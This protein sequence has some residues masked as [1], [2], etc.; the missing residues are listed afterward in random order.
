[1]REKKLVTIFG[2]AGCIG[3]HL[4]RQL[5]NEDYAIRVLDNM[6]YGD[7]GISSI[8]H[9]D[10]EVITAD[11]SDV[12]A[13]SEAIL[14]SDA[15]ILLAAIIGRRF[16]D[17]KR[18]TTR[19]INLLASSVIVDAAIEHG[20][21]RFLFASSDGVYGRQSGLIYETTIPEPVSLHTRLKLR[22]EERVLNSKQRNFHPTVLRIGS[23]YGY[24]ERLRLDLAPNLILRDAILKGEVILRCSTECRA[25]IHVEDA[26][27][28]FTTCLGAHENLI[29]GEIFNV[30]CPEKSISLQKVASVVTQIVPNASITFADEEPNLPDYHLSSSKIEKL[31]D[32][33]PKRKLLDGLEEVA[34][35]LRSGALQNPYS[36]RYSNG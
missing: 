5:L 32:F 36:I 22:M 16:Q 27:S 21:S 29:S 24:S 17:V 14:G 30:G 28:A 25:F 23:G 1:M 4:V 11:I 6:L 34:E 33:H 19:D 8:S 13:V 26:A 10:L 35:V 3:S 9:P 12:K 20:V 31:L 2:G 7:A 18:K 15:V